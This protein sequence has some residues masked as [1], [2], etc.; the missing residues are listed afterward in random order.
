MP[1]GGRRWTPSSDAANRWIF[2][3]LVEEPWAGTQWIAVPVAPDD[4]THAVDVTGIGDLAV[5]SL[6]AHEQYLRGLG[7]EDHR[8]YATELLDGQTA[9]RRLAVRWPGG[10]RVRADPWP[11]GAGNLSRRRAP[12]SVPSDDG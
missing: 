10:R 3:E 2:P 7:V 9:R 12:P 6:L 4:A 1:S 8:A 11:G 5:R